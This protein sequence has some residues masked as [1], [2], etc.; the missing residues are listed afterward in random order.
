MILFVTACLLSRS[1]ISDNAT[2]SHSGTWRKLVHMQQ[3]PYTVLHLDVAN[4]AVSA[5]DHEKE[6]EVA[7]VS[8]PANMCCRQ[9][10]C[11]MTHPYWRQIDAQQQPLHT[12]YFKRRKTPPDITAITTAGSRRTGG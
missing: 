10:S 1:V 6:T 3:T 2:A 8:Y 7:K 5:V 4:G 12:S 9:K 11:Y